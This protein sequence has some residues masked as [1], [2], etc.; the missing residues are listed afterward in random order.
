[1]DNGDSGLYIAGFEAVFESGKAT[2]SCFVDLK[3]EKAIAFYFDSS[4]FLT[5]DLPRFDYKDVSNTKLK[6]LEDD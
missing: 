6:V 2:K 4:S 1:M 3:I 5:E